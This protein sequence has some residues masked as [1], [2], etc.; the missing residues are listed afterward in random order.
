MLVTILSLWRIVLPNMDSAV[1]FH[2]LRDLQK[3]QVD[4]H[5]SEIQCQAQVL[6]FSKTAETYRSQNS[7]SETAIIIKLCVQYPET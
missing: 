1:S 3:P 2:Q 4:Q 6:I 5:K 7:S